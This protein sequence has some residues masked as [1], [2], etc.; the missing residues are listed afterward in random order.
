MGL[1]AR[2][3]SPNTVDLGKFTLSHSV[4][5]A[6]AGVQKSPKRLDSGFRRN[7][8]QGLPHSIIAAEAGIVVFAS[9]QFVQLFDVGAFALISQPCL[10]DQGLFL[11]Q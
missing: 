8:E 6:K 9:L 2:A 11:L 5:P 7:D 3:V 10:P 4:T 1:A